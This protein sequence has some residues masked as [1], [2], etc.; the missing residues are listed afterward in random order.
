MSF[1]SKWMRLS[2]AVDRIGKSNAVSLQQARADLCQA[3]SDGA[4]EIRGRLVRH[5][6]RPQKS[7][8]VVDAT[9]FQ[10]PTTLRPEDIDWTHSRPEKPWVLLHPPPRHHGGPWHLDLVEVSIESATKLFSPE[11]TRT[12]PDIKAD[13][14]ARKTREAPQLQAAGLIIAELYPGVVPRQHELPNKKLVQQV[15]GVRKGK[16]QPDISQDTILRAAGRRS[17]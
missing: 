15:N 16:G 14:P 5:S 17:K 1:T 12:A 4:L 3:M 6:T 10:T 8:A 11:E 2:E 9:Q 7:T 13:R